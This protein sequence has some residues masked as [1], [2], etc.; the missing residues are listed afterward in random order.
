MLGRRN[1]RA[2]GSLDHEKRPKTFAKTAGPAE[3]SV[4]H[5]IRRHR[6][7]LPSLQPLRF[8]QYRR[9]GVSKDLLDTQHVGPGAGRN[10]GSRRGGTHN[11]SRPARRPAHATVPQTLRLLLLRDAR[12]PPQM[13]ERIAKTILNRAPPCVPR[14]AGDRPQVRPIPRP[15]SAPP[16]PPRRR[17]RPQPPASP[18]LRRRWR[19]A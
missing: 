2:A 15:P 19:M 5:G 9:E 12:A 3:L 4:A 11:L 1:F 13:G 17:P 6:A 7:A 18:L 10:H 8:A 16:L 14:P